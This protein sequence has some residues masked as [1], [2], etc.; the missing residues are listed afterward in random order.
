MTTLS[1][2]EFVHFLLGLAG[3]GAVTLTYRLGLET[4]ATTVALSYLLVVLFVAA[5]SRLWVGV[6]VSIASMIALNFFFLPP[7]GT[8]TI[9]DPQNWVALFAFLAVSLV[10]SRLSA[11]ARDRAAMAIERA[12]LIEERKQAELSQRS[13]EMKSALLSSVAHNLRTPLTAIRVAASNLHASWL[14]EIQRVEQSEIVMTEVERLTRLFQNVLE[15][16]RIDAGAIAPERQWVHPQEIV[17][18]S[19]GQVEYTLQAHAFVVHDNSDGAVVRVDPRL[20]SAALA[21]LLEN[22]AQYSPPGSTI[23][24]V[25]QLT[26]DGLLFSVE[27]NGPGISSTDLP[28]LFERFYRGDEARM[29]SSGTG[30]GLSITQGLAAAEGGRVWAENRPEGGAR[31]CLLIPAEARASVV[32]Q[33]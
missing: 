19:R 18:A 23:A 8:F 6:C 22:A 12:K 14:N 10:A 7:V 2:R 28:H 4:N 16:T 33:D 15:M 11:V 13:A 26:E 27:D 17:E 32:M 25:D 1:H 5:S 9:A 3:V 30:M 31:F 29:Y 21:H 24:V 20:T